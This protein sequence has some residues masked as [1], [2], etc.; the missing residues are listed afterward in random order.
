[1]FDLYGTDRL[2]EWKRFRDSLENSEEPLKDVAVFWG[3]APFVSRYLNPQNP[4][5]WPDPW[6]LVLDSKLDDLAIALCML[7]TIKLTHR[8]I[9]TQCEIHMSMYPEDKHEK[10]IVL[11][12]KQYILNMD[13]SNVVN[14]E[15]LSDL[16]TTL[17]WAK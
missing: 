15:N 6:H 16:K 4:S 17:L 3:R 13:W 9:D 2:A 11:V 7:Y 5:S 1:M 14:V 12:N 8:F 10:Y